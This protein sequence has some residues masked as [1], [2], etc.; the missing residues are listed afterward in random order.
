[1]T[2]SQKLQLIQKM[3]GLSQEEMGLRFGVSFV[4]LNRWMNDRAVPRAGALAKIDELYKEYSGEKF[5]PETVLEAK[6]AHIFGKQKAHRNILKEILANP[7]VRDQL[8][9]SLT[10]HS[11][12]IEGSTMSEGD[13]AAVLFRNAS[14]PNRTLIEQLEAKNHQA[15]LQYLFAY[16]QDE[17]PLNE[18]LILKLHSILINA[19]RE[20][21]GQYRYHAVRILGTYVPTAN[22]LKIPDLMKELGRDFKRE[23][24]D[25]MAQM[26]GIHARFEKIHPF[27]DGNG[28]V[29]RLMMIAMALRS[30][31][32]P[33]VIRSGNKGLYMAYL[34]KA[35]MTADTSL[36]EDFV[37]DAILDGYSIV[38]RE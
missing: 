13:T 26:T 14:L 23:G 32:A 17:Q 2:I 18:E 22:Y 33:V 11:N 12:K 3:S 25:V 31:L 9:L 8:Y 7:D 19:I 20:D 4:T 24:K 10:F 29:G 16:L 5:I 1:M 21:A 15:A 30:N 6:K 28:R 36:L 37:C 38:E 35:Q 34:N 27:G